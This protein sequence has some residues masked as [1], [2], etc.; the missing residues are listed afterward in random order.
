MRAEWRTFLADLGAEFQDDCV[1]SFGNAERERRMVV[2]GDVIADLSHRG[3]IAAHGEDAFEFLQGQLTSD[4]RQVDTIRSQLS[5]YLTPKGRAL[6]LFRVFRRDDRYLLSLPRPLLEPILKR[7]R[8]FVLR[9]R[10][11]LEDA[12]DAVLRMGLSG[13]RAERDLRDALGTVPADIDG[14]AH[15][16]QFTVIRTGGPHP[17]FEIASEDEEALRKLW[18]A[19]NVRA[20]PVGAGP[21]ELLDIVAGTPT[22]SPETQELFVPQMLN[23]ELLGGVSFQKGCYTGQEIVARTQHLGKLK[24]R[25]Y[26]ARAATDVVPAPGTLVY[27]ASLGSEQAAGTVVRAEPSPEGGCELLAVIVIEAAQSETIRLGSPEGT[28]LSLLDLPYAV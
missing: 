9:S 2:A 8:M 12:T 3:L 5:A 13:P 20:A 1:Q 26:R 7:L 25:M 6:A 14:V 11:T 27:A 21:W 19:L 15:S 4:L 24:R 22:V 28:A 16:G 17:R 18:V 23:L 10:V